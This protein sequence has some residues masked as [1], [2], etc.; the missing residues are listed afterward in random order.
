ME[1]KAVSHL[2]HNRLFQNTHVL[3]EYGVGFGGFGLGSFMMVGVSDAYCCGVVARLSV[4]RIQPG[5]CWGP[6]LLSCYIQMR[7]ILTTQSIRK[8]LC[9]HI[10]RQSVTVTAGTIVFL[11]SILH[12]DMSNKEIK[13]LFET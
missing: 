8:L 3:L 11:H 12:V 5:D 6:T 10:H 7:L 9:I 1:V 2:F 13:K 4:S